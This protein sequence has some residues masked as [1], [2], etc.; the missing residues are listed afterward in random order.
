MRI[1]EVLAGTA[2]N[3]GVE[4]FVI[5]LIENMDRSG[6][7][8]DC[9]TPYPCR[10]DTVRERIRQTGARFVEL[11]LPYRDIT[12]HLYRLFIR[13]LRQDPYDIVHIHGSRVSAM[14]VMAAGARK[15]GAGKVIVHAHTASA[16]ERLK[17]RIIRML[18][19]AAMAGKTDVY[20][21]CSAEAVRGKFSGRNAK[22]A[23]IIPNGIDTARFRYDRAARR[24]WRT[25]LG[26]PEDAFVTGHVGRLS[27]E[28]NQ[29]FLLEILEAMGDHGSRL[30]LVG[31]GEDRGKLEQA[32]RDKGLEE[33]V[34]FAGSVSNVQDYLQAMDVFVF[35]SSYEGF[36]IAAVEA[37]AS[38]LP[39]VA[40]DRVP[41]E[42][43][44]TENVAFVSL[45]ES[46]SVWKD[47]I[48]SFRGRERKDG[49]GV[50]RGAG[51]DAREIAGSVRR[52]YLE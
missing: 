23:V 44:M 41:E 24:A 8:T 25:K 11:D 28:K 43:K 35:P 50:V 20:C 37:Q 26:I 48:L 9:L 45:E 2:N 49:A 14:A 34:I 10:D 19:N 47:T 5:N 46:A 52:L 12:N 51:F 33:Q 18:G 32:V 6:F 3:G 21:A 4:S 22:D 17:T 15:A 27:G 29:S 7:L 13:F 36:G 1:L 39:V 16:D 30:L 31:E 38:G 40:S 42:I